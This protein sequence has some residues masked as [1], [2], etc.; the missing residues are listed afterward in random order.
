MTKELN[1]LI[2]YGLHN[3]VTH[4]L[5]SGRHTFKIHKAESL[6]MIAHAKNLIQENFGRSVKIQVV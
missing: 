2:T 4:S 5:K 6:K 1:F 3:F